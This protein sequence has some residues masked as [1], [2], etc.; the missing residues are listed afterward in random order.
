MGR[1]TILSTVE[2]GGE[3]VGLYRVNIDAGTEARSQRIA[4]LDA[5]IATAETRAAELVALTSAAEVSVTAALV[6]MD[7][8]IGAYR[9][10]ISANPEGDHSAL[11]S[12]VAAAQSTAM[13]ARADAEKVKAR[14][15]DNT[16]DLSQLRSAKTELESL[17]LESEIEAWCVDYTVDATGEVGTIEV[18][19]EPVHILL[20][21]ECRAPESGDGGLLSRALMAPYQAY[22]N[23]AILPGWQKF[24]PTFR[25]GVITAIDYDEDTCNVTLDVAESTAQDLDVN[26]ATAL[27][28][29]EIVYGECNSAPFLVNDRVVVRFD[30]Q[31]WETPKVIGFES[32]PVPCFTNK[33]VYNVNFFYS[34]GSVR[35]SDYLNLVSTEHGEEMRERLDLS[36]FNT[37]NFSTAGYV[38]PSDLED[39]EVWIKPHEGEWAYRAG[40]WLSTDPEDDQRGRGYS[41]NIDARTSVALLIIRT[42]SGTLPNPASDDVHLELLAETS[43]DTEGAPVLNLPGIHEYLVR[44]TSDEEVLFHVA[45][46]FVNKQIANAIYKPTT[47]YRLTS[48]S[49]TPTIVS[50]LYTRLEHTMS[51]PP[52]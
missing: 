27:N 19:G 33:T 10:A 50:G 39:L 2:V 42:R 43:A 25:L 34:S 45:V 7:A 40:T 6:L 21:P 38:A 20:Q 13:E 22:Y 35:D 14:A 11:R 51:A 5:R 30:G 48:S 3:E 26:Q 23:A 12:A 24:K 44:R 47:F 28:G 49:G 37:D 17:Q 46:D 31:N 1:A 4:Q 9:S 41:V 18:P 16:A 36:A 32:N 29:V 52:E 8:A 15:A